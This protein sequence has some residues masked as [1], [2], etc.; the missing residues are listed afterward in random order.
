[1]S[2]GI[3]KIKNL[4]ELTLVKGYINLSK[5]SC[6]NSLRYL[7]VASS[8]V[9]K[10]NDAVLPVLEELIVDFSNVE[11]L[12]WI[13][14]LKNLKKL[15]L[16]EDQISINLKVIKELDHDKTLIYKNNMLIVD[17]VK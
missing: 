5:L 15:S 8:I 3:Y 10:V 4:Q 6:A 11:N 7:N 13:L 2:I 9:T 14:N 12:D 17:E 1:M 16:S